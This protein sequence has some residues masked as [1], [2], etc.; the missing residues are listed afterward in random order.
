MRMPD[1]SRKTPIVCP[2]VICVTV[3]EAAE[4]G[5]S[6]NEV[7]FVVFAW[8]V[9]KYK[10]HQY[11]DYVFAACVGGEGSMVSVFRYMSHI[12]QI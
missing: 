11:L 5:R 1:M 12:F 9:T 7:Y 10:H 6:L 3:S 8:N 4:I 2:K